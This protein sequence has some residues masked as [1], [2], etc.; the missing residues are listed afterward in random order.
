MQRMRIGKKSFNSLKTRTVNNI[1]V[2]DFGFRRK[3]NGVPILSK[4]EIDNYAEVIIQDFKPDLLKTPQPTPIENFVELYLDLSVDYHNLSPDGNVL[5]MIAFN[6]G[7]VEVYDE[8]NNKQL[9]EVS[10]GT[11]FIDNY[12]LDESQKGRCRFTFGHEP[13]HWV[14]HR[15]KYLINKNQ[16]SLFDL[17]DEPQKVYVKCHKKDVGNISRRSSG[18]CDDD[19][20]MEW[21]AD[22][23]SSA[24]LMPKKIFKLAADEF[25]GKL[26]LK[27]DYFQRTGIPTAFSNARMLI[28]EL[29]KTFEVSLQAA[30]V[31]LYKLGYI[32]SDMLRFMLA[33]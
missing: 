18:F 22:Y 25:M 5:G 16:L 7:F 23:F 20:W 4:E 24:I 26:G 3:G 33:M 21:H 27:R 29:A 19:E 28:L 12:L 11:V 6:D 14:F 2:V 17:P 13:G 15:H 31:R 9:I 10:Q 1:S 32:K 8:N 30:A